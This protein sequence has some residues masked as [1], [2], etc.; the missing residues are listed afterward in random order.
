MQDAKVHLEK[1]DPILF[2]ILEGLEEIEERA[3]KETEQELFEELV[4][5]IVSQQ[6]SVKASD[7]IF[8]RVKNL[9]PKKQISPK[10]ILKLKDE[11]LKNAGLS[12]SKVKYIKDLALKVNS[13][14]IELEK[15]KELTDEEVIVRLKNVKGIGRWTAEMFLM[16]SLGRPDIFS[17]GDLG[18]RNAIK[19]IYKIDS[20]TEKEILAISQKWSPFRTY[21]CRILWKSLKNN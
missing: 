1:V 15:L 6:L 12:F 11:E 16:F 13:K 4:E 14:E 19:N 21:A 2:K 17:L 9:L 3:I 8:G 10:N 7:T 18:L 20:P 5:S